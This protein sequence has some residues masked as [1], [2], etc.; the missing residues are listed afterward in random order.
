MYII[1]AF[2]MTIPTSFL[3]HFSIKGFKLKKY[4]SFFQISHTNNYEQAL[5][6]SIQKY[7]FSFPYLFYKSKIKWSIALLLNIS[8]LAQFYT[9]CCKK[10]GRNP[11]MLLNY[12]CYTTCNICTTFD[13][14][15]CD[16]SSYV[17]QFNR[18]ILYYIY[19][20]N[21]SSDVK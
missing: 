6:S 10:G 14:T 19:T 9:F 4:Y 18:K 12:E 21:R 1:S 13:Q 15:S 3:K 11:R 7:P 20:L 2:P 5:L 17:L 8:P 16:S